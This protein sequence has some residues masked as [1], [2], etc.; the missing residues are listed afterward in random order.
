MKKKQANTGKIYGAYGSNMNLEQMTR[1]CPKARVVGTGWLENYQLVFRGS[2]VASVIPK[3]GMRTPVLLWEITEQC[4]KALDRYEGYPHL[5]GKESLTVQTEAGKIEAIFYV[6]NPPYSDR[7]H[8]PTPYYYHTISD[9]YE[10]CGLP[11]KYLKSALLNCVSEFTGKRRL[12]KYK[13]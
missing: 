3:N 5:Y 10:A 7:P 2:G 12:Q 11:I 8:F 6:I 9:G 13:K 4:E 1:R